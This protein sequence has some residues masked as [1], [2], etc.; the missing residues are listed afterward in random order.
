MI[1]YIAQH[2]VLIASTMGI[3]LGACLQTGAIEF[4]GKV[5]YS[6]L[7][8]NSTTTTHWLVY[9]IGAICC[10]LVLSACYKVE[11]MERELREVLLEALSV[12]NEA[13]AEILRLDEELTKEKE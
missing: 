10:L 12:K 5:D 13:I 6:I 7:V 4:L 11:I 9:A 1:R 3:L 8:L 2:K